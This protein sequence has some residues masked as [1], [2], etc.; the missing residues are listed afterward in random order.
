MTENRFS[1]RFNSLDDLERDYIGLSRWIKVAGID[2]DGV[3]RGKL[4][5]K[6]KFISSVKSN[7]FGWCSVV[8]GWD[9]NDKPYQPELSISNGSN[10]YRDLIATIDLDSAR[11][12]PWEDDTPFFFIDFLNPADSPSNPSKPLFCCPRGVLK[13]V[14]NR[15]KS[16]SEIEA[17][18]GIEYEYFQFK[19]SS[20]SM[21]DKGFV[22]LK[23]LTLGM[24]GYS[25]LRPSLN[26][27]YFRHLLDASSGFDIQIE[28]HHTE[29]GPGVYETALAYT[30]ALQMADNAAL[31]KLTAKNVGIIHNIT[32]SFMAKPH[33]NLP[34]CSGHVHISLKSLKDRS[35]LFSRSSVKGKTN[36]N[37]TPSWP[38]HTS[39]ISAQAEEFIAGLMSCLPD[40]IPCLIPTVNGYKRLVEGFWA[41]TRLNWGLDSR[42]ASIRLIAPPI[43]HEDSTRLEIRIPGADMNP[44]F[45]LAA[46]IGAGHYGIK[47]HLSLRDFPPITEESSLKT[48][49]KRTEPG[50]KSYYGG[51][52]HDLLPNN[53]KDSTIRFMRSG[54]RAREIFGD[55]FVDHFGKTRLNEWKL[56][57]QAVTN[58]EL[59]RYMELA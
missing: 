16:E 58:W 41:A 44:H 28:G 42:L 18:A 14:L 17:F 43:C 39:Q 20:Q 38:D 36:N 51:E 1:N 5:S 57:N 7:G 30:N 10:G 9:I 46:I 4:I 24:H 29:T 47:K 37:P 52:D 12:I 2:V 48:S 56:F 33:P 25:V 49:K 6:D 3:I 23:P 21:K 19:E 22:G 59:E 26:Q 45:A 35:N 11:R 54:S 15:L 40:L 8:F 13:N 27:A 53:L 32:P 55:S 31:F 50:C 34:G